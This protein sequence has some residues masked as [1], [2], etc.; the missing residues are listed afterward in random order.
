MQL[1]ILRGSVIYVLV[2]YGFTLL[3]AI[4][5]SYRHFC[6][7]K[8]KNP[9]IVIFYVVAINQLIFR[10]IESSYAIICP[11][12]DMYEYNDT[13]WV[14]VMRTIAQC[15]LCGLDVCIVVTM[16]QVTNS[17]RLMLGNI[18]I[19]DARQQRHTVYWIAAIYLF[20]F[21]TCVVTIFST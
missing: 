19:C 17:L 1:Q 18:S 13:T 8:I 4:I 20:L 14:V 15:F 6:R 2:L 11:T 16:Y 7:L 12:A 21:C 10:I 3:F 5:N 9:L